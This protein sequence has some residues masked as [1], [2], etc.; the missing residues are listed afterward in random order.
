MATIR[1]FEDLEIWK[2]SRELCNTVFNLVKEEGFSRDFKLINQINGASGSVMDNVA[3]GFDRGGRKEF[4]N[5]LGIAKGSSAEVKSQLYRAFDRKYISEEDF[6]FAYNLADE[7]NRK[8]HGLISYLNSTE[9]KG[10]KFKD[11]VEEPES[12]YGTFDFSL[13]D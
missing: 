10:Q 5:F 12:T 13:E 1:R 11:R 3:E 8:I 2:L 9:T 4:I 7:I 6:Q